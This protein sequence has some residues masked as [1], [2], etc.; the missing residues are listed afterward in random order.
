[1]AENVTPFPKKVSKA[2]PRVIKRN[3]TEFH[4]VEEACK[5]VSLEIRQSKKKLSVIAREANVCT[6]TVS[7]MAY[8]ETHFP[9][10]GT[11][12]SIL[13]VLGYEVVVR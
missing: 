7:R 2:A 12:L 13:K 4:T 8:G 11:I 9:R 3:E 10:L 5:F 1:M 6:S